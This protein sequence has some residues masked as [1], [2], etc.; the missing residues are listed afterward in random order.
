[1]RAKSISLSYA[2]GRISVLQSTDLLPEQGAQDM[3]RRSQD[4]ARRRGQR[5]YD[6]CI[7]RCE[8]IDTVPHFNEAGENIV[9]GYTEG[10]WEYEKRER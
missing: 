6:P 2:A 10:I 8:L 1:M 3:A 4:A 9:M 7:W 5:I